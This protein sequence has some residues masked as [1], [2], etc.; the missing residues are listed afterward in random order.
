MRSLLVLLLAAGLSH[1]TETLRLS[2][3][4]EPGTPDAKEMPYQTPTGEQRVWVSN[5]PI[6]TEKD[7]KTASP[8][9]SQEKT[10]NVQLTDDGT[11]AM[12]AAT[13][14]M[15]PGV[16]RMAIIVEG[17]LQS[18]PVLRSVP[19]GT[20]FIIEGL[21]DYDDRQLANLARGMM[22]QPPL[23]PDAAGPAP[24][25]PKL[26]P[27]T[28]EELK[29]IKKQREKLGI[30]QLDR[31]PDQAE[32]DKTLH[33]GMTADEVIAIY[34]KPARHNRKPD[35][36]DFYLEYEIAPERRPD[37]PVNGMVP[38]RFKVEF[39]DDKVASWR[40]SLW[41]NAPRE[42][43]HESQAPRLLLKGS[44]PA[45][46]MADEDVNLVAW[47]EGISIPD[48]SQQV[49]Q[50]DLGALLSLLYST[51]IPSDATEHDTIRPDCDVLKILAKHLPD[52]AKLTAA[53][54]DGKIPLPDLHAVVK[55]FCLGETPIPDPQSPADR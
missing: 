27:Y 43:K 53:A 24:P 55:R 28:E 46:D 5:K 20:E 48:L 42:L 19:L 47:I 32:L 25:R 45:I 3:V 44:F 54:K 13:T 1:A 15:R 29:A 41:S 49:S 26:V 36:K 37:K 33:Q 6:I 9:L 2:T 7:V 38:D 52:I 21:A 14:P 17:K 22:G 23:R 40:P 30:F 16:D 12:I 10:V 50:G 4:V 11:A 35:H 31:M 51:T 8:S 18:A 39:R 34:G